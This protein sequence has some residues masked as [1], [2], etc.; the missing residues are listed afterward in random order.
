MRRLFL[1][2]LALFGLLA[3]PAAAESPDVEVTLSPADGGDWI[4]EFRF[5]KAAPAWMF[6]RSAMA[7]A[8]GEP[9]RPQS[10]TVLTPGVRIER[11]GWHDVL[12]GDGRPLTRVKIRVKPWIDGLQADYA[13]VLKFSDGGIAHYNGQYAVGPLKN[14]AQADAFPRDTNG[15]PLDPVTTRFV[16]KSPESLLLEGRVSRG[17]AETALNPDRY[18]YFGA[19]PLIETE[20]VAAVIDPG[21]PGWMGESLNRFTPALLAEHERRLGPRAGPKPTVYVA[22]GG[23]DRKGYSYNGGTLPGLIV[24]SIRGQD[25]VEPFPADRKSVV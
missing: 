22:W 21:L 10:W 7:E 14:A 4:A 11:R 9:W 3:S 5:R 18:V 19:A 2:V 13:P 1:I 24:M 16:V 6:F 12:T 23:A 25:A 20:S 8:N 15:L 17:R